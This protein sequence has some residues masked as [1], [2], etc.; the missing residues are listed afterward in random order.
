MIVAMIY[1]IWM[2]VFL[3]VVKSPAH[4]VD[5]WKHLEGKAKVG[6]NIIGARWCPNQAIV[7]I[8]SVDTD[9]DGLADECYLIKGDHNK[10]HYR[11][12]PVEPGPVCGCKE[13]K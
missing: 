4:E 8:F 5:G 6:P 11:P 1:L 13:L 2:I 7:Q 12:V 3:W 10:V 9:R